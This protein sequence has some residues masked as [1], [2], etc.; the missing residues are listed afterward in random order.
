LKYGD[1][2][3]HVN[4]TSVYAKEETNIKQLKKM[5]AL[6]QVGFAD[7][8]ANCSKDALRSLIEVY[9]LQ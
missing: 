5:K 1:F 6:F 7:L 8:R 4:G 2:Y 9:K 3:I